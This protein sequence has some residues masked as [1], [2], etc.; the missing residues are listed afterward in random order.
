MIHIRIIDTPLSDNKY[1]IR[2][3]DDGIEVSRAKYGIHQDG[4]IFLDHID[5]TEG[6]ERRGY[7]TAILNEL[8]SRTYKIQCSLRKLDRKTMSFYEK[9][10]FVILGRH[11]VWMR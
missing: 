3:Y 2:V 8:K 5:T 1:R 11:A 10:G 7:A 6:F 4:S 9:N